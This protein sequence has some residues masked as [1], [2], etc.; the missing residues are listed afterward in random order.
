MKD[1]GGNSTHG[2]AMPA[3]MGGEKQTVR[4]HLGG[5]LQGQ[6]CS[7]KRS[8]DVTCATSDYEDPVKVWE[9]VRD[10]T[11]RAQDI[12][13]NSALQKLTEE[14]TDILEMRAA[15]DPAERQVGQDAKS[16][17]DV[18]AQHQDIAESPLRIHVRAPASCAN[19]GSGF[20]CLGLAVNIWNELIIEEAEKQEVIIHGEGEGELPRDDS[21]LVVCGFQAVLARLK[22]TPSKLPKFRFTCHNRI[23]IARGLGSSCAAIVSGILASTAI[24]PFLQRRCAGQEMH[25][26]ESS[27]KVGERDVAFFAMEGEWLHQAGLAVEV[28]DENFLLKTACDLEGHADNAAAAL[29]GGLQLALKYV[30]RDPMTVLATIEKTHYP[31]PFDIKKAKEAAAAV[32]A[33]GGAVSPL[34]GD[35]KSP[36]PSPRPGAKHGGKVMKP[37]TGDDAWMARGV[38]IPDNLKCVLFVPDEG[39]ETSKAREVLPKTVS[40]AD[41]VFNSARTALLVYAMNTAAAAAVVAE[42]GEGGT[43]AKAAEA[44]EDVLYRL[45]QDAMDDRLHQRFRAKLNPHLEPMMDAAQRAG[46]LGVCLSGAGPAVLAFVMEHHC[47]EVAEALNTA[48]AECKKKGKV[49]VV[50]PAAGGAHTVPFAQE[51]D[52]DG[53]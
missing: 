17:A 29:F 18:L 30:P 8:A 12:A 36:V 19:L 20:D 16:A 24:A 27:A 50:A 46:A 51:R 52:D 2:N 9:G 45:L 38:P 14:Q 49:L 40:L 32:A 44:V 1:S 4:Q 43:P 13:G 53:W 15:R 23:P 41:A 11:V 34:P 35:E 5:L 7:R 10:A 6:P 28:C 42:A 48:A 33:A 31:T 39:M 37:K 47:G 21:N 22:L 26:R 25:D 3:H